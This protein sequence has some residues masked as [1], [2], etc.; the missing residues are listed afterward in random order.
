VSGIII[1]DIINSGILNVADQYVKFKVGSDRYE[2]EKQH[3]E[4]DFLLGSFFNLMEIKKQISAQRSTQ[5][6]VLMKR[7]KR[8]ARLYERRVRKTAARG[9]EVL[10]AEKAWKEYG[11]RFSDRWKI[12]LLKAI[13][14]NVFRPEEKPVPDQEGS[15]HE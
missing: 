6:K 9:N 11:K 13:F 10:R 2:Y 1:Y 15:S 14:T 5:A 8:L 4:F 12:K 7:W 3:A